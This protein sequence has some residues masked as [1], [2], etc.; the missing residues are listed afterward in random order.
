GFAVRPGNPQLRAS[1]DAFLQTMPPKEIDKLGAIV[2][3]RLR[4]EEQAQRETM[5]RYGHLLEMV[6]TEA[7]A[8]GLDWRLVA[9]QIRKESG[10]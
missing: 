1:L 2:A 8:A 6:K 5:R 9:A 10:F 4:T 3:Q 7:T